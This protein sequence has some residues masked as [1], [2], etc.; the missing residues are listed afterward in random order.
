[1]NEEDRKISELHQQM[2]QTAFASSVP[3]IYT[4]GFII[5]QTASDMV[6]LLVNNGAPVAIVNMSYASAK[7]LKDDMTTSIATLESILGETIKT[8][9]EI[10]KLMSDRKDT[11]VA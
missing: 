10:N 11:N 2:L 6:M 3:R 7:S 8:V 5:G 4:N 1:M 9:G